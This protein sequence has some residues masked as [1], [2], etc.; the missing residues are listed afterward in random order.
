[1]FQPHG[2]QLLSAK[3]SRQRSL[4]LEGPL[5]ARL[6]YVATTLYRT[7]EPIEYLVDIS[8]VHLRRNSPAERASR[9]PA[10]T[11]DQTCLAGLKAI[12]M[13]RVLGSDR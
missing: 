13:Y 7:V 8:T 12:F 3:L 2:L 10:T 5:H 9:L 1:V 6:L 11:Q 4:V